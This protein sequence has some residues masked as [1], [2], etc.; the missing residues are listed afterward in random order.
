MTVAALP[1]TVSYLENGDTLS[2]A[3]PFRFLD[4]V[5]TAERRIGTI[6]TPLVPGVDFTATGGETDAGGTLELAVSF[7]GATLTIRRWTPRAQVM[8]YTTNDRFPARSHEEALDRQTMVLQELGDGLDM[9]GGRAILSP[10]GE[11]G[12]TLPPVAERAGYAGWAAGRLVGVPAPVPALPGAAIVCALRAHLA[13]LIAPIAGQIVFLAEARREGHFVTR[14]GLPPSDPLEGVF[15]LSAYPGWYYER[16]RDGDYGRPEWFGAVPGDASKAAD[17]LDALEACHALCQDT[18]LDTGIYYISDTLEW[19]IG[20]RRLIGRGMSY[21]FT[22]F[23]QICLTGTKARTATI[24]QMGGNSPETLVR[25]QYCSDVVFM[26]TGTTAPSQT[27]D[28]ED[29]VKGVLARFTTNS[30]IRRCRVFNSP[31]GFHVQLTATCNL[32]DCNAQPATDETA[33]FSIAFMYGGYLPYQYWLP[34]KFVGNN[35]SLRAEGNTAFEFPAAGWSALSLNYGLTADVWQEKLEGAVSGGHGIVVQG[36]TKN[37]SIAFFTGAPGPY[38]LLP[39]AG[40]SQDQTIG[41]CRVDGFAGVAFFCHHLNQFASINMLNPYVASCGT[42]FANS[43]FQGRWSVLL[44][45]ALASTDMQGG[46]DVYGS[47][48]FSMWGTL[49]RGFAVP[50]RLN[51]AIG[52]RIEPEIWQISGSVKPAAIV[53]INSNRNI[54]KP[55]IRGIG[56]RFTV[57]IELD[58]NCGFNSIHGGGIDPGVLA[59]GDAAF[60][61]RFNGADAR[62]NAAFQ[63]AGNVLEGVTG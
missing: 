10:P 4:G 61:V 58:A 54:L 53:L 30:E 56:A 60:K 47:G 44:G 18:L 3:V 24:F 62:G 7:A 20:D 21:G 32:I 22:R 29:A 14:Q 49:L 36:M 57:G 8:R 43:Q 16:I 45:E 41:N 51:G 23:S 28:A 1:S 55:V 48:I 5:L 13:A 12:F 6:V 63:A 33:Q 11:S 40:S 26:R 52:A 2:F 15:V 42:A 50:V 37:S 17:T 27:G 25:G 9:L 39:D 35:G 34:N 19:R 46:L 38:E 31:V 59:S